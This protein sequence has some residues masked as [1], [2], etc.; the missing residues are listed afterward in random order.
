MTTD[1]K[2]DPNIYCAEVTCLKN[3]NKVDFMINI[4]QVPDS[5]KYC[6]EAVYLE[7]D[8]ILFNNIYKSMKDYFGGHVVSSIE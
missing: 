4:L 5:E 2:L 3:D 6:V 1:F 8:K 7:G